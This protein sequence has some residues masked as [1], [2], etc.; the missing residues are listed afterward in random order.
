MP[1]YLPATYEEYIEHFEREINNQWEQWFEMVAGNY[2]E[3][4]GL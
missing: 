2:P 1:D 4:E 3:C